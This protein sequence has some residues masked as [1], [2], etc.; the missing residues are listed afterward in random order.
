MAV[1]AQ[2]LIRFADQTDIETVAHLIWAMEMYYE[3]ALPAGSAYADMVASTLA[4]QE[5]T[6][7]VLCFCDGEAVGIACIAIL[8]P[9]PSLSGLIFV[10]DLFVRAEWRGRGLARALM[11]FLAGFACDQGIGRIDLAT[12][13]DNEGARKLYE[14]LGGELGP[15][16]YYT[17]SPSVL[18]KMAER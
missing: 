13:Q 1:P 14:R 17:F 16:V 10:K 9:G 3:E 4:T 2:T 15:A 6:R 7:F 11:R 12:A 5:G 18:R 8:R